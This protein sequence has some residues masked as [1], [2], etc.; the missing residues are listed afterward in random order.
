[1]HEL[2][3]TPFHP[4]LHTQAVPAMLLAG[5][6]EFS[7]QPRQPSF[8]GTVLYVPAAQPTHVSP[9]APFHPALQTQPVIA[10]V[11][12]GDAE[13]VGQSSHETEPLYWLTGHKQR[14]S[15]S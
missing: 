15:R 3:F 7:G 5:E 9:F 13:F 10:V 2:A 12:E 8:P 4:A 11:C 1:M 6:M 14:V